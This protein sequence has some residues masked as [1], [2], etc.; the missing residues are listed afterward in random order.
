MTTDTLASPVRTPAATAA[1]AARIGSI[2]GLRGLVMLLMLVDHARETFFYGHQVADPMDLAAVTPGLFFT[3][4]A[5]HLCAPIFVALTGLAA[6]LYGAR[7]PTAATSAFLLKRGLFLIVLELTVIGF[8]WT[9]VWP[10]TTLF[11]QVIWAIGWSMIALAALIHLPRAW[12]AAIG[13]VIVVGHNLLDPVAIADGQPGHA[14]WAILHDR[15]YIDLWEGA[16]ART[17]Y[18]VLPW[19]GVIAL[20]YAIG[21]WFAADTPAA[22]RTRRLRL[23]GMAALVAFAV[24]RGLNGYGDPHPWQVGDTPLATV[25]SLLNVTKYPPSLDF[26]LLTLGIGALLLAAWP[27]RAG[28]WLAVLGGAPLFFYILH[29]YVLHIVRIVAARAAG[30]ATADLPDVPSVAWLWLIAAVLTPPLWLATRWFAARKRA[31]GA[32]WMRYL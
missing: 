16:R 21:P 25:M 2:D 20:G 9:F 12:I 30:V 3:R 27:E 19:I 18:P 6:W 1:T 28:R 10:P 5:A 29:L 32:R 8:A 22:V 7:R 26:L 14:L 17:S 24:V 31:S 11:L 4:L 13:G 15:G 23:C